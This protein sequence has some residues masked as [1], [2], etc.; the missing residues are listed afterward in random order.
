MRVL[1]RGENA[2]STTSIAIPAG[3]KEQIQ[4]LDVNMT[5]V[6]VKALADE[7]E[8]RRS[9]GPEVIGNAQALAI[10]RKKVLQDNGVN[11]NGRKN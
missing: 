2:F 5:Q 1:Q 8:R 4:D 3:L 6:C 7:V 9:D 11:L 10:Q